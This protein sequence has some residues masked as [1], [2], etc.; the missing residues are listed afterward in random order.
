MTPLKETLEAVYPAADPAVSQPEAQA[1]KPAGHLRSDAVSLEIP[2]KIHGSRVV[3]V[4]RGV[5]PRTEPFEEQ[6]S[7]MIVFPQG[8]VLRVSMA[9]SVGQMLILTNLKS[10]QDAI[11]RVVKVRKQPSGSGGYVEIEFTQ[12]QLGYWGVYFPADGPEPAKKTSSPA[13][14]QSPAIENAVPDVSS[15]PA[16]IPVGIKPPEAPAPSAEVKPPSAAPPR[17][18]PQVKPESPFISIGSQENVQLAATEV[19]RAKVI[20]PPSKFAATTFPPEASVARPTAPPRPLSMEELLADVQ[21]GIIP[22]PAESSVGVSEPAR[23]PDAIVELP[24]SRS[25]AKFGRPAP[26]PALDSELSAEGEPFA[27]RAESGARVRETQGRAPHQNPTLIAAC[28]A[29]LLAGAAAGYLYLRHRHVAA[30]ASSPVAM[31]P[32]PQASV[33]PVAANTV[34]PKPGAQGKTALPGAHVNSPSANSTSSAALSTAA[35]PSE[36]SA[37]AKHTA[38]GVTPNLFGTLNAH[39]V[40]S[41]SV[42]SQ[43]PAAPSVAVPAPPSGDSGALGGSAS[44]V[45]VL[46][47]AA[48]NSQHS[49]AAGT[50]QVTQPRLISSVQPT[51]PA[52][53]AQMHT[54]GD[55]VIR[56]QIDPNGKVA[57]MTVVSGPTLLQ[58]A[59]LSALRQWKY[60]PSKLDGQPVPGEVLVTIRFRL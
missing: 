24:V 10:R 51:Y 16:P 43:A 40:P 55:V 31:Q 27:A 38:S 57:G 11:C 4:A 17:V 41:Q 15:A 1:S 35:A 2:V 60:Q 7:T 25:R 58:Q 59:A 30:V 46:P 29:L 39:P 18:V 19:P 8:G 5:T 12:R 50:A 47:A 34:V 44:P 21:P 28:A 54:Q 52:V 53:A 45:S 37:P 14:P 13:V 6:T 49:L 33:A 32:A 48:A 56:A 36:P 42:P 9:V 22:P 3:E 26:S 20:A 23:V